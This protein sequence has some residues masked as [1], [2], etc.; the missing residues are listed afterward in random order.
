[1]I[2][3]KQCLKDKNDKFNVEDKNGYEFI[4]AQTPMQ[5]HWVQAE[6]EWETMEGS[7]FML[8]YFVIHKQNN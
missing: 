1:M 6:W 8:C 4:Q 7:C 2:H 5:H 3:K